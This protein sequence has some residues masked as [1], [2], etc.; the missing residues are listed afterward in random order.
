LWL[1]VEGKK[2]A[3]YTKISH[4]RSDYDDNLLAEMAKQLRL[5]RREFDDLVQC[6]MKEE[7]YRRRLEEGGYL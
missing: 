1:Y 7:E 4:G 6:P 3:I 5:R 2:T